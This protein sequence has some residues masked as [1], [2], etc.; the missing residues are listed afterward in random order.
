M[1]KNKKVIPFY[2]KNTFQIIIDS[3]NYFIPKKRSQ[4]WAWIIPLVI[5]TLSFF[6]DSLFRINSLRETFNNLLVFFIAYLAIILTLYT[7]FYNGLSTSFVEQMD[8]VYN[9][10]DDKY[11]LEVFLEAYQYSAILYSTIVLILV[12]FQ[13]LLQYFGKEIIFA[14]NSRYIS[15]S[16][17]MFIIRLVVI[18]A[19]VQSVYIITNSL[20]LFNIAIKVRIFKEKPSNQKGQKV[21][22]K[23]KHKK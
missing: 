23:E 7:I 16:I 18:R 22:A 19:I 13:I 12:L 20:K 2:N 10:K 11:Y 1:E 8:K 21:K 4:L 3:Y 5:A 6:D 9:R 15:I 17:A 14:L